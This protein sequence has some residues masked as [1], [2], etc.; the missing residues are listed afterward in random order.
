MFVGVEQTSA[1]GAFAPAV[2]LFGARLVDGADEPSFGWWLAGLN[3]CA[4]R[5]A[6]GASLASRLACL[7]AEAGTLGSSGFSSDQTRKWLAAGTSARVSLSL[8][9]ALAV[10][11]AG[12]LLVPLTRDAFLSR[13]NETAYEADVAVL[14][15]AGGATLTLP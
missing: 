2:R 3:A 11:L 6:L 10:E 8:T 12:T 5:V 1:S 15:L 14:R 13:P 4:L 9:R 7:D